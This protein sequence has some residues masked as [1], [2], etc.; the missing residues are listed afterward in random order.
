MAASGED[1]SGGIHSDSFGAPSAHRPTQ[2]PVENRKA[3]LGQ[4]DAGSVMPAKDKPPASCKSHQNLKGRQSATLAESW[5]GGRYWLSK[6]L[7]CSFVRRDFST[8][9]GAITV[10]VA[11]N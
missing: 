5:A 1:P 4:A 3:C 11:K 6:M 8:R 2:R 9:F 7:A 10:A